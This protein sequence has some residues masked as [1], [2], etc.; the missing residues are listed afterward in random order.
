LLSCTSGPTA[1]VE[2]PGTH[3]TCLHLSLPTQSHPDTHTHTHT[4]ACTGMHRHTGLN[5]CSHS[6]AQVLLDFL[7]PPFGCPISILKSGG[8]DK[9]G[10]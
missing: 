10:A 1:V 9:I 5:T 4:H 6:Q 8:K 2:T 7:S 3:R